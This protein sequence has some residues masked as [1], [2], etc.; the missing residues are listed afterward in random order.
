MINDKSVFTEKRT[1]STTDIFKGLNNHISAKPG[2]LILSE[3][4]SS[5]AFPAI[6]VA[7]ARKRFTPFSFQSNNISL[8]ADQGLFY[9]DNGHFYYDGVAYGEVSPGKKYFAKVDDKIAIFPDKLYFGVRKDYYYY[10]GLGVYQFDYDKGINETIPIIAVSETAPEKAN[11]GDKY[12]NSDKLKI[13][14]YL[15]NNTW[16]S[17]VAP[18]YYDVYCIETREFGRLDNRWTWTLGSYG[19]ILIDNVA[20]TTNNTNECI[21]IRFRRSAKD[22]QISLDGFKVGDWISIRGLEPDFDKNSRGI[23]ALAAGTTLREIG[24]TYIIVDNIGN[25]VNL[26]EFISQ[27]TDYITIE[28]LVPRLDLAIAI[29]DRIWGAKDSIVYACAP[30][31]IHN[32]GCQNRSDTAVRLNLSAYGNIIGCASFAGNPVFFTENEIIRIIS[33]YDGYTI[34][35][36]PACSLSKRN[37]DS[38]ACI[39]GALYYVSDRGVMCYSGAAPRKIAFNPGVDLISMVGG[40]D[41]KKYYLS[42]QGK[43]YVYDPS[44][45]VWYSES[46]TFS[47]FL[48]YSSDLIG[49]SENDGVACLYLLGNASVCDGVNEDLGTKSLVFA[50]FD[51][52]TRSKKTY[53]RIIIK[54]KLAKGST[55]DI[56]ISFDGNDYKK[57]ATINGSGR[58]ILYD[59]PIVPT[60]ADFMQISL[61]TDSDDFTLASLTREFVLH[62][63]YN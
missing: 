46:G 3:N 38:L 49:I 39:S 24:D 30:G 37:P 19:S 25:T 1:R 29:G 50:P 15:E 47:S 56:N 60:R 22:E 33:V 40:T 23:S 52:G 14:T 63:D 10:N 61:I 62:E 31:D 45:D 44:G 7:P 6:T 51:E 20:L 42:G 5:N 27:V 48:R 54:G 41:G 58:T 4:F 32:W 2:E 35:A 11:V 57:A 59:I 36:A 55:C 17:A 9:T 53:S 18:S 34:S 8:G 28:K 12:I 16:G 26:S 21:K 43:T 13:Y